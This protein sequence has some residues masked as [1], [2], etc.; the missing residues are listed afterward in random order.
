MMQNFLIVD[1]ALIKS[2]FFPVAAAGRRG[3]GY[4]LRSR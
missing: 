3:D 1:C 2:P 4:V